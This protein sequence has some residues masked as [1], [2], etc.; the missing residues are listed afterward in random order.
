MIEL[1]V[2]WKKSIQ[3]AGEHDPLRSEYGNLVGFC[4][5]PR[6]GHPGSWWSRISPRGQ[7]PT[8]R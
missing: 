1:T 8:C 3:L 7:A 5:D 6:L 2:A 4:D